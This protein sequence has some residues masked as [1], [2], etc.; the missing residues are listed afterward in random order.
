MLALLAALALSQVYPP[1][2]V[3]PIINGSVVS[4]S[5]GP[6]VIG[7]LFGGDIDLEVSLGAVTGGGSIVFTMTAA[8]PLNPSATQAAS[9]STPSLSNG[10]NPVVAI[11]HAAH[12]SSVQVSWTVTGTFSA[13]M[14]VSVV[15]ITPSE[16]QGIDGGF[17]VFVTGI[18]GGGSSWD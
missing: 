4:A 8:D 3:N 10:S 12:T 9:V 1:S 13:A 6:R 14:W 11:L 5:G 15:N 18:A 17:P 16:I 7:N 2:Q